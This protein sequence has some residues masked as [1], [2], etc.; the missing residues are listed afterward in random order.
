MGRRIALIRI[1]SA[2]VA[3]ATLGA[4]GLWIWHNRILTVPVAYGTPALWERLLAEPGALEVPS[5]T[6]AVI[7]PHHLIAATELTKF[8]RGLARQFQPKTVI[9]VGPNHYEE[10]ERNIQ[11]CDCAYS[12]VRGTLKSD[13]KMIRSLTKAG[14]AFFNCGP[15]GKEHSMYNHATFI[16][17]FFPDANVVPIILKWKT[18]WAHRI[19]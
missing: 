2:L 4:L 8:Y 10:G 19:I 16:K 14:V 1:A 15:F 5:T 11:T 12:T 18:Q 7:L 13:P 9:L 3:I 17:T 6:R